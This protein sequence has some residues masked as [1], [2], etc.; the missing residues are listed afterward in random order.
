MSKQHLRDTYSAAL[1]VWSE[2]N[3]YKIKDNEYLNNEFLTEMV[4]KMQNKPS[5]YDSDVFWGMMDLLIEKNL[6]SHRYSGYDQD[7]KGEM[8]TFAMEWIFRYTIKSF[9]SD[10]GSC[11]TFFTTAILNCFKK[12]LKDFYVRNDKIQSLFNTDIGLH[13]S[14]LNS[15]QCSEL[16][17]AMKGENRSMISKNIISDTSVGFY[18]YFK[19]VSG[20][21]FYSI[22]VLSNPDDA[23]FKR[24]YVILD[25]FVPVSRGIRD[26]YQLDN[27]SK[28]N[29]NVLIQKF[30]LSVP[31]QFKVDHMVEKFVLEY[32]KKFKLGI[33][34]DYFDLEQCNEFAGFRN[35]E[36]TNRVTVARN[37]GYQYFGVF[38]DE[39]TLKDPDGKELLTKQFQDIYEAV[40][41][42]KPTS[43][44]RFSR[45]G[46]IIKDDFYPEN[47]HEKTWWGVTF[48]PIQR[49]LI[50]NQTIDRYLEWKKDTNGKGSRVYDAPILKKITT[51]VEG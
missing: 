16:E 12:I 22:K 26:M 37:L 29:L 14:N 8:Y 33:V 4:F 1:K 32:C 5:K 6:S 11:F 28:E 47:L 41:L 30:Q 21:N 36:I 48:D 25:H 45:R 17:S 18:T 24:K 27:I 3:G 7:L 2:T 42:D 13:F 50:I 34:I 15:T 38:S 9:K 31:S 35:S 39:W 46:Y 23:K 40:L 19:E 20:E 51:E 44:S 49:H 43:K 10:K